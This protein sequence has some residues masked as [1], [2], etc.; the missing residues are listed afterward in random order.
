MGCA[1]YHARIRFTDSNNGCSAWLIRVPRMNGS[2]PQPLIDYLIRSEYATLKFL[3][4]TTKVPAPRAFDYGIAGE[5][6]NKI[7]VSYI[8]MEEMPGKPWNMQGPRGKRSA[9]DKDKERVWKGLADI[10]IELQ[11]HPFPRV[12]S[13]LPGPSP[14]EP[15]VV[16][17]LASERFLVLSPSG[18]F[19]TASDYYASFVEQNMALIA[20]GQLFTSFPA[21]AYLVFLYLKSQIHTLTLAADPDC[22]SVETLEKFYIKHVDDK[23][24][25]LMVDDELNITGIID[26][27]MARVVPAREA[28]G[29]SLV[30][31]EMGDIYNGMS[32]LTVHD[33]ALARFLKAKGAAGLARV[34]SKDERLRRFFFGLDVD[35]PWD[36]TLRLVRGIWAAFGVERDTDWTTW[37]TDMMERHGHDEHLQHILDR[38]G[39]G[40]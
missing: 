34:M 31:A 6:K 28:F 8:L 19:D 5:N 30:T 14:S 24:D 9:D 15:I 26:W 4:T 23:G 20:D 39:P 40:P 16:S 2:I 33:L 10:L 35:L 18:P 21:N 17:A 32:S 12:G 27:Q 29:P 1:N 36:E 3:E 37:K 13:L 25:H 7:G 22:N 11:N 38:F